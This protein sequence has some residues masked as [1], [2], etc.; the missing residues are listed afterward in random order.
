M[1]ELRLRDEMYA[2]LNPDQRSSFDTIVSAINTDPQNAHFFLQGPAGTGKTFLYRCLC[3]YYRS[4]SKIVLY[5]A[6]SSIAA[7]LLPGGTTAHSRFRIP[8]DIHEASVCNIPKNSQ[9][10]DLLRNTALII[11]DEVPM[12]HKF[13]FEAVH[14]T[15]TN[16]Y[17]NDQSLFGGIPTLFGG[18]FAQ[19]LPVVPRGNRANIVN[20]CLQKSFLWPSLRI[21]SLRINMRVRNGDRNYRFVD[22][23]SGLANDPSQ[24]G[25]ITIPTDIN[26][27]R[28]LEP[29]YGH[30]YPPALLTRAYIDQNTFR[31]RAILTVRNDTVAEIND[32]ILNRLTGPATEFYSTDEVEA[33]GLNA[34]PA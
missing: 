34:D 9:L 11:W 2:Q 21:L 10:A 5:V 29:F 19:I 14:R 26:Q 31:D 25:S 32:N 22:W 24:A 30:I 12:Q 27:H 13:C 8:I 28:A 3:H 4:Q 20:A 6:S 1:E 33:N 23:I 18:D 16:I 17:S 15:L 7:L